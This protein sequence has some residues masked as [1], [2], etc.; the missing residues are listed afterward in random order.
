MDYGTCKKMGRP[1]NAR[2]SGIVT[3]SLPAELM[4]RLENRR[5]GVGSCSYSIQDTVRD[6]L[7]A[8]LPKPL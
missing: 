4:D 8:S 6:V 2:P 5:R 1:K 7:D 3:V